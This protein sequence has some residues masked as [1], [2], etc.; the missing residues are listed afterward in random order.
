MFLDLPV[1]LKSQWVILNRL[2]IL[3]LG[4]ATFK[5]LKIFRDVIEHI[6]HA[7]KYGQIPNTNHII[8]FDKFTKNILMNNVFSKNLFK[9]VTRSVNEF[10]N[11]F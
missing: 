7:V 10:S 3:H 4:L 2:G 11:S 9:A 1:P 5:I 6:F 8:K